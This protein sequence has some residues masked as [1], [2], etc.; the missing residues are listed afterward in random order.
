METFAALARPNGRVSRNAQMQAPSVWCSDD[1]HQIQS[2]D[3]VQSLRAE[4]S[5]DRPLREQM[6]FERQ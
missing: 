4:R 3:F 2:V 1:E 5:Q 6:H